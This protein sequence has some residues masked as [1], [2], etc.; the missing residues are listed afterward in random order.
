MPP[1]EWN[2]ASYDRLSDP[3]LAMALDVVDRLDLRG[4]ERVL[5]AGCGSGRVTEVLLDRVPDGEVVAVDGSEAM[6]AQARERLGTR[7][8]VF[9]SD[10]LDLTLDAPVDAILSTATFHWI[11]DHETLFARMHAALRP[12]GRISAQCGGAGNIADV[13]A[14]IAAVDH[15]ALRGWEGPWN[16]A[17]PAETRQRMRNAGFTDVWTWLQPWPV[18]PPDPRAYFSTVILGSHLERLPPDDRM[19]FVDAVLAH[20]EPPVRT[21]Y[22]RLNLLG[23]RA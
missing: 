11:A 2:A 7:A 12:G 5:D 20:F 9:A 23:R 16:Y 4:D 8:H 15:P 14:A 17:T 10:L 3:Q 21:G 6:V 18:D 22:V 19:P 1:R 13:E